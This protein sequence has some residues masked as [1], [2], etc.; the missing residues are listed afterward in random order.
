MTVAATNLDQLG[1]LLGSEHLR[2]EETAC[3]SFAADG[4]APAAVVEP[5]DAKELGEVVAWARAHQAALVP[6]TSGAYLP[7]GNPPTRVDVAISLGRLNRILHYDP[8]DLTLGAEAGLPLARVQEVLAENNLFLPADPPYAERAALGGLLATNASGPLRYAYGTWRDFVV[9]M[10][11]ISGEGKQVKTGGRV[12]K[13]VAGYDLSKLLIGSLGT[14]GVVT[15]VNFKCFPQP[16]ATASFVFAF[17]EAAR[18]LELRDAIVHSAWQPLSLDLLD[19]GAAKLLALASLSPDHWSLVVTVG[20]VDKVIR[21]YADDFSA[22][23]R[24]RAA[25]AFGVVR[26][27]AERALRSAVRELIP[28]ARQA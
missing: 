16:P 15:E 22:L 18:A 14:L 3:E 9:G 11:F 17:A 13:N 20:G 5:A 10:G 1:A 6:V 26:D 4:V 28:R 8:A 27:E 12:V 25:A 2:T 23:A 21:R 19:P 7:L 24:E